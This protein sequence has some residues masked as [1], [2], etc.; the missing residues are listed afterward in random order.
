MYHKQ[1]FSSNRLVHYT[2]VVL[3]LFQLL[4]FVFPGLAKA[5]NYVLPYPSYMP[6]HKLYRVHQVWEKIQEKWYFGSLAK[7]KYHLG[8]SGKYLVEAKTLFEY[9][10]YLLGLNA[11][12]KSD[13]SFSSA[14]T[15][16]K[17]AQR[18]GKNTRDKEKIFKGAVEKH[19]TVLRKLLGEL[20]P[21]FNWQPE[22]EKPIL[23]PIKAALEN[24]IKIRSLE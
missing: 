4:L 10:Q 15:H 9:N 16:L 18:E 20:P 22:K 13:E 17:I 6:G 5:Q 21:E 14:F 23:I 1:S 24:S 12:K 11:L 3:L 19:R 2:L 7:F 8:L